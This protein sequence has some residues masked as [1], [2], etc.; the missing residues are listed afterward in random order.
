LPAWFRSLR[1]LGRY[2]PIFLFWS[3]QIREC[4]RP[5]KMP[6]SSTRA[7]P[8]IWSWKL[9]AYTCT[10]LRKD[11]PT[12]PAAVHRNACSINDCACPN[13]WFGRRGLH[14]RHDACEQA[15][16]EDRFCYGLHQFISPLCERFE[17]KRGMEM[18]EEPQGDDVG[19]LLLA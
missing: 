7:S 13:F 6:S 15:D 5:T 19:A 9:V 17:R 3:P 2:T 14:A 16:R 10:G 18:V 11:R 1:C 8:I 4:G 12:V